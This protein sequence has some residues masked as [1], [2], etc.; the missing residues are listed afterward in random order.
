M[1]QFKMSNIRNN[2]RTGVH[3][4]K[5]FRVLLTEKW[6]DRHFQRKSFREPCTREIVPIDTYFLRQN[7]NT[8]CTL[9][10]NAVTITLRKII[11]LHGSTRPFSRHSVH[12][13]SLY[14]VSERSLNSLFPPCPVLATHCPSLRTFTLAR[15]LRARAYTIVI[16]PAR[17]THARPSNLYLPHVCRIHAPRSKAIPHARNPAVSR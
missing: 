14:E 17:N 11:D 2:L 16:H 12:K 9:H 15:V 4:T 13:Y 7:A 10:V 6:I 1:F 8:R 5:S 3:F